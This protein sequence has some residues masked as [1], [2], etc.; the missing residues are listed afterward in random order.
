MSSLIVRNIDAALVGRLKQRAA[1]HGRSAEAEHRLILEAALLKARPRSFT[2]VL[3]QM[4]DVG[5]DTDF[6]RHQDN[7]EVADVF[8]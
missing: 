1:R 3:G 7:R 6:A 4:P 2:E 5:R 8:D